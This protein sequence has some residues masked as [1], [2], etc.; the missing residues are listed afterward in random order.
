[1]TQPHS[2]PPSPARLTLARSEY[3]AMVG[4]PKQQKRYFLGSQRVTPNPSIE[5]TRSLFRFN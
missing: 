2:W 3:H 5:R 4:W 1:M